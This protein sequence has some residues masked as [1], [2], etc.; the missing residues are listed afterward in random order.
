MLGVHA[1]SS[2]PLLVASAMCCTL[3]ACAVGAD[4]PTETDP[5]SSSTDTG[6]GASGGSSGQAGAADGFGGQGGQGGEGGEGGAVGACS[7]P[8]DLEGCACETIGDSR[9]CYTGAPST[10]NVGSCSDGTQ[11]CQASGEFATWTAC[12][13]DVT[14]ICTDML[15]LDCNGLAGCADPACVAELG[16][17]CTCDEGLIDQVSWAPVNLGNAI[18]DC[19][20]YAAQTFTAGVSGTL[21]GVVLDI[22]S[23]TGEPLTVA[24]RDTDGVQPLGSVLSFAIVP[25][26]TPGDMIL[27]P[28]IPVV[29]GVRY[30]IVVSYDGAPP[31]GPSGYQG[32]WAGATDNTYP[33]GEIF[34]SY[35]DGMSW[36]INYPDYDLHFETYVCPN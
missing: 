34:L 1:W 13:G 21:T 25:S 31:P 23:S 3:A 24:I 11:S 6:G 5:S 16:E 30:A 32:N 20:R 26:A 15:D 7:T 14:E 12:T 22:S 18:N 17:Q 33:D 8:L 35:L 9:A 28:P 27:L 2:S 10:Q 36:G 4:P 19:C 29:A